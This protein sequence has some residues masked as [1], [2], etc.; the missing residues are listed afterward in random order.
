MNAKPRS[1]MV[2][3]KIIC[4]VVFM[5]RDGYASLIRMLVVIN[6]NNKYQ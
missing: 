4:Q 6:D 3:L 5:E 1:D 2:R